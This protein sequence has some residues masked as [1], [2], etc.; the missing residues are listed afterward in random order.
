MNI[1]VICQNYY[2]EQFRITDI[3]EE[4][5]KRGENVTV[6][7]G[8]PN[9]PKGKIEKGY[10]WFRKRREVINGVNVIRTWEIG[11]RTGNLFR[12]LNYFSYA[13]S[14]TI[15][16]LFMTKKYDIVYVYQLSPIL[17]AIPGII[18]KKIHKKKLV[19]YCLDLWPDS[20]KAGGISEQSSIYKIFEK[21]SNKIYNQ[22]DEI[23]VTSKSFI[24]NMKNKL[25]KDINI[26]YLPQYAEEVLELKKKS[27]DSQELNLVFA[28]NIGK[29]QSVQTI[30]EAAENIEKIGANIKIHIVG[31]GSEYATCKKQA[32]NVKNIEF[33]GSKPITEMQYF[34]DMAD[35]MLVTLDSK[36]FSS[37]TLPGKVQACMKTGNPIIAAANGETQIIINE[38]KCGYCVEAEN[39]QQLTDAIIKFNNL[40]REEK[41]ILSNNA[42]KYYN[43]NF[44]KKIFID[45]L[46][47]ILNKKGEKSYV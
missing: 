26:T 2:P 17:M 40:P 19:L 18:Y 4:L 13:F 10:R 22:S 41:D 25:K 24:D 6:L 39:A 35:A 46:L 47:N 15:K 7:T 28:G 34:Y 3:C 43:K 16:T 38:A 11:R 14:A 32:E 36:S 29:A 33:Y 20:L 37:S 30:I 12:M 5:I 9:Y 23:L 31:N 42:I 27:E 44:S 45:K 1:L 21:I 8:L